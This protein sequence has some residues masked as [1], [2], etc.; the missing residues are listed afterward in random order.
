[1]AEKSHGAVR[2][3]SLD[4]GWFKSARPSLSGYLEQGTAVAPFRFDEQESWRT[5]RGKGS[6]REILETMRRSGVPVV[7]GGAHCHGRLGHQC[8]DVGPQPL[9]DG[10]RHGSAGL[11]TRAGSSEARST[12]PCLSSLFL[13]SP[14]HRPQESP[15]QPTAVTA[16]RPRPRP[17]GL[18]IRMNREKDR[19]PTSAQQDEHRSIRP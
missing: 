11:V 17:T 16:H 3:K 7:A 15:A 19:R 5:D 12:T 10:D 4:Y 13:P 14:G 18:P 6:Y 9:N 8:L 2:A 1:M